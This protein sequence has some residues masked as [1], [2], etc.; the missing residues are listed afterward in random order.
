MIFISHN[1]R[2]KALAARLANELSRHR[3]SVWLDEWEIALGESIVENIESGLSDATTLVVIWSEH[4]RGS[5]WVSTE[6]RAYIRR[7]VDDSSLRIVPIML[8]DTPLPTLVA[9]YRGHY[10]T[11]EDD[12]TSIA[13][14][15][16]GSSSVELTDALGL[17]LDRFVYFV[18]PD[19]GVETDPRLPGV[20]GQLPGRVATMGPGEICLFSSSE[21]WMRTDVLLSVACDLAADSTRTS[22]FQS[23]LIPSVD[24]AQRLTIMG[25]GVPAHLVQTG[26]L[27]DRDWD[28]I[29]RAVAELAQG[30][31]FIM[32]SDGRD[33]DELIRDARVVL[34]KKAPVRDKPSVLLLH[35]VQHL[36]DQQDALRL[37]DLRAVLLSTGSC[38]LATLDPD[39][40]TPRVRSSADHLIEV[41]TTEETAHLS[42]VKGWDDGSSKSF[43]VNPKTH[44]LL[45]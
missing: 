15:L 1:S 12:V 19:T 25:S 5:K 35:E 23:N 44:R 21:E 3:A 22:A 2:D 29:A 17:M 41:E 30:H 7:R 4:A 34:G 14:L 6:L 32:P 11:A 39:L 37:R 31:L 24:L 18:D 10:L 16:A 13:A 28:E 43:L 9:E 36:L 27:L 42:V 33:F 20:A 26:R 45:G 38:A 8:D 40:V